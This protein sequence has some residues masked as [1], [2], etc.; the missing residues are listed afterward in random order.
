MVHGAR[1]PTQ[2]QEVKKL[3]LVDRPG[4]TIK[5]YTVKEGVCVCVCHM[6]EMRMCHIL[7]RRREGKIELKKKSKRRAKK[8]G[9]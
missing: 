3:S 7:S 8:D 6:G 1:H 5:G 2:A 9:I 4:Y